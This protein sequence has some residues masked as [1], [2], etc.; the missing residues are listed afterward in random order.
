M[1]FLHRKPKV[2][3]DQSYLRGFFKKKNKPSQNCGLLEQGLHFGVPVGQ[4]CHEWEFFDRLG[5]LG[6]ILLMT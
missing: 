4:K 5:K 2:E 3:L 1:G 6:R